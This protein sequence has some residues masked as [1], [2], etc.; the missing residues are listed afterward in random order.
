MKTKTRPTD[1]D[2]L[3]FAAVMH[4]G[5][6]R[7]CCRFS[8]DDWHEAN[9]VIWYDPTG[10]DFIVGKN[11]YGSSEYAIGRTYALSEID[12]VEWL[13]QDTL[14]QMELDRSLDAGTPE[15]A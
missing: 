3:I 8:I 2:T 12:E 10:V 1:P 13:I 7:R 15:G 9:M 4:D 6:V 11:R 14:E 5:T